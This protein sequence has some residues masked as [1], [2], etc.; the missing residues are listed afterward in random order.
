MVGVSTFAG[1]TV[2]LGSVSSMGMVDEAHAVDGAEVTLIWGQEDGGV[3]KVFLPKHK[4]FGIRATV[5]TS[6]PS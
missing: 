1:Y 2:N 5:S 6:A 4:Q 3:S